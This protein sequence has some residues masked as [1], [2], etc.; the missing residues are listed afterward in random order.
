M[1]LS[2]YLTVYGVDMDLKIISS[3]CCKC[4]GTLAW[5]SKCT[6]KEGE[7][8]YVQFRWGIWA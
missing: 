4:R 7:F 3:E 1:S 2:F 8:M 6:Q 5:L